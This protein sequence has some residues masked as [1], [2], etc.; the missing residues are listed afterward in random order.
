MANTVNMSN[1][2]APNN[3]F[4]VSMSNSC[5]IDSGGVPRAIIITMVRSDYAVKRNAETLAC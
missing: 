3:L 1:R 2:R 4:W 5:S